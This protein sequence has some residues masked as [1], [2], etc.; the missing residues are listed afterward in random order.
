MIN[1]QMP[2]AM[3]LSGGGGGEEQGT[4]SV[5]IHVQSSQ[6]LSMFQGG[7]PAIDA[8]GQPITR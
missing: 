1:G 8:Q 6:E 2:E 5:Y 3:E 7:R 4:Y